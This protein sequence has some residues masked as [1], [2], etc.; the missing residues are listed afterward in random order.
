MEDLFYGLLVDIYYAE[1]Q[2]TRALPK[3]IA[4]ATNRDLTERSA[5]APQRD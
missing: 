4:L 3:M 2:I 1:K 5:S